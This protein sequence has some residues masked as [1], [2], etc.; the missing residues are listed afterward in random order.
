MVADHLQKPCVRMVID[1]IET[2]LALEKAEPAKSEK[3]SARPR[4]YL[5]GDNPCRY[6]T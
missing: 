1:R 3:Q 4:R 2:N 5:K 6:L